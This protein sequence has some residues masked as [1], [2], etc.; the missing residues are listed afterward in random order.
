MSKN[1]ASHFCN[2]AN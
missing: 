1:K 2:A